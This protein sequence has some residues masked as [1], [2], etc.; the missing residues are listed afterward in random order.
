MKQSIV[1]LG[2]HR[3]GTSAIAGALNI[4]SVSAGND[5]MPPG[6]DNPKGFFENIHLHRIDEQI[7]SELKSSWD[8]IFLFHDE[9]WDR[10]CIQYLYDE[11]REF[12][13]SEFKYVELF[14]IKDPRICILF[15]FWKKVL[16]DLR[17][18]TT[19]ILPLRNPLEVALSL[20]KRNGFS[21]EK[22]LALWVKHTFFAE[23]YSR[24]TQ[25]I[26]ITYDNLLKNTKKVLDDISKKLSI[27][28]PKKYSNVQ[29]EIESFLEKN[30]KHHSLSFSDISNLPDLLAKAIPL[31]FKL[32]QNQ[33]TPR[34]LFEQLDISRNRLFKY[35]NFFYNKEIQ[36]SVNSCSEMIKTG[37]ALRKAEE[38]LSAQKE[39]LEQTQ[40]QLQMR[41][42]S[43]A[44]VQAEL[45][46][47]GEALREAE[48]GLSEQRE[49]L[50]QTQ[51]QLQMREESFAQVQA[52][53]NMKGE[54]LR[55]TEEGLSEQRE[56]LEQTQSQLRMREESFAQVQAELRA[57][58]G[59]LE[60]MRSELE[61]K[62]RYII[63]IL[64]S[65]S[66]KITAPFRF[67]GVLII[68]MILKSREIESKLFPKA[69]K[70]WFL[71][72]LILKAIRHPL[73][74]LQN[75]N[76]KNIQTLLY[77]LKNEDLSAAEKN[78]DKL[79][80]KNSNVHKPNVKIEVPVKE[81]ILTSIQNPLVSII[82][83]VY[84]QWKYT[85]SCIDAIK[86]HTE[87]IAYE[88]IVVDDVSTDE[89]KQIK[90]IIK[91]LR[92][93]RNQKNM[94]F[95]KSCNKAAKLAKG[96]YLVILNNDTLVQQHWLQYLIELI[97][98]DK[99]IGIVG[100]KFI[101]P[102]GRLQEA[103]GIIWKDATG[104]N[105]GK[106]EEASKPE[107]NYVKEVDYI[108]GACI[109][110][111]K[112]LWEKVGGFDEIYAPAYFE[113]A[114]LAFTVRQHGFKVIYQ[115]K[116]IVTHFEGLSCGTNVENGI[117]NYQL[118][119][120][121]KFSEK[122]NEVLKREHFEN[123]KNVF[124]ARD[125]SRTKKTIV[126]IDH[127]VPQYDQDA[128]SKTTFQCLKL[129]VEMGLNV[130]FLP[131]NFFND[132]SY[133]VAL[134]Q[135]GI[136][137]LY[138]VW[139]KENWGKWI[140]GNANYIDY[141]YCNR[142]H[143]TIKYLDFIKNNTK[144]KIIYY[145]H[146]LHYLSS[147]RRYELERQEEILKA[148]KNWEKIES[149]ILMKSNVVYF[150][151]KF[152]I[153]EIKKR[154]PHVMARA[155]PGYIFENLNN[156]ICPNFKKREHL[157][158]VGGFRHPP[159]IDGIK[160]FVNEIFPSVLKQN[161][162]IKL[163]IV[164][165][166]PPD[167]ISKLQSS[168]IIITGF[169]TDDQLKHYYNMCRLV[170]APLR[171]GA[172]VK[173]KVVEAIYYQVPVVCT[174]VAGE[175]LSDIEDILIVSDQENDFAEKINNFYNDTEKLYQISSKYLP[176]IK[177]YFSKE[178]ALEIIKKDIQSHSQGLTL[179]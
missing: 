110:I 92:V 67:V 152:E 32:T 72:R 94:G 36:S 148:F 106:F 172:G 60:N 145:G 167:E 28:Y 27:T 118:K 135:I 83:P 56:I 49:I 52:E 103:G 54:A 25:R 13:Q 98:T 84:N 104:W 6:D 43:F 119:N 120:R 44:Q 15:P 126:V 42:E 58:N 137:V 24:D 1:V 101:Y 30:L 125:R 115:P 8:D 61:H 166:H 20:E 12:I 177:K 3:S 122:W 117:K 50:E 85:Y 14:Y 95:L 169:V 18:D 108:S 151:S 176:Y 39:I 159:N 154:F 174:S 87:G 114:D 144:S 127:Y 4:L 45:N 123:G 55:E 147:F 38:G 70:R 132:E 69:T 168:N 74:G 149:E 179:E 35:F 178:S 155:I 7:L 131:D 134:E 86:K 2:M 116:S 40:S 162:E 5:L 105:F 82:V 97:E 90:S 41:E 31:F 141:F 163:Y 146:E 121:N 29:F 76:F 129:F 88:I 37:E 73:L 62:N 100:P 57:N 170:V 140:R 124:R 96:E 89:T 153:E 77:A 102:D 175:G 160:W 139:Y 112:E 128:G 109:M 99:T 171:Y 164:G 64:N 68:K 157:L 111:K 138:G 161:P 33:K 23:Y 19:I 165:S 53:L 22:S 71:K 51:S 9:W 17:I 91:N 10:E 93:L 130:K 142:P 11:A 158:F 65:Y 78:V 79:L 107:Y 81:I 156:V 63:N 21:I 80:Q 113:D 47:K 136:E 173:G 46:M 34:K 66:W 48:E 59:L 16:D 143:I 75:I 150:P 26:F 133:T